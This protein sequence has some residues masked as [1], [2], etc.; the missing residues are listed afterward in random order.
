[1]EFALAKLETPEKHEQAK[2]ITAQR[3]DTNEQQ[4]FIKMV[5]LDFL[6]TKKLL[7]YK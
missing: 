1:M 7:Q 2:E 3:S 6:D 5:L 4:I